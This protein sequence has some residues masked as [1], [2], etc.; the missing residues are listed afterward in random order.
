[1]IKMRFSAVTLELLKMAGWYEGRQVDTSLIEAVLEK[2]GYT[3]FPIV[4]DFL[5][6]FGGLSFENPSAEPPAAEDWHFDA[7]KAAN[8][9]SSSQIR[10]YE[11]RLDLELCPIG[12][13]SRDYLIILMAPGGA[14]Y[15]GY[16]ADL[17]FVS[18]SGPDAIESFCTG[19][20]LQKVPEA[21][22]PESPS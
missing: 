20:K 3:A 4:R 5:S 21:V 19:K 7:V 9:R 14:V 2:K 11:L 12:E 22:Q 8:G 17:F 10:R 13:A 16:E 6:Q 18:G 15:A 1:M